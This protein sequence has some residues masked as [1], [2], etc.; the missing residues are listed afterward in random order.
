MWKPRRCRNQPRIP[1]VRRTPVSASL[2]AEI[3]ECI[4]ADMKMF[5]VSRSFVIATHLAAM[6]NI[7]TTDYRKPVLVKK[8]A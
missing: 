4:R 7:R 3:E 8:R 1:G 2:L 6:Y 5:G